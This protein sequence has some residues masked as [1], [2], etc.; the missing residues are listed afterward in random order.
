M[1]TVP[2]TRGYGALVDDEDYERVS[3]FKWHAL[4]CRR[5]KDKSILIVYAY[6]NVPK[7]RTSPRAGQLMHRF[8]L[9]VSDPKIFTDHQNRIGL[10]NQKHNLRSCT[11]V[12]NCYNRPMQADNK[13][14]FKGVS[15]NQHH[16]RWT[17]TITVNKKRKYL[18]FF[19]DPK[20][21][22]VVYAEAALKYH[23]E[24]ARLE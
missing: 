3:V 2:L 24:F 23:G 17:A 14:G 4:V 5:K 6:R 20:Q 15:W 8:I 9:D 21:A 7:T 22:S 16:N 10:D 1:K 12:Q 18:G 19:K 13:S 11:R